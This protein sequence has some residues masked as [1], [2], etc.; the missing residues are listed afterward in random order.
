MRGEKMDRTIL[1]L[2]S[3]AAETAAAAHQGQTR[4]GNGMPYITH[5]FTV[6]LL[7]QEA[8]CSPAVITAGLLHDTIEDTS[9]TYQDLQRNFGAAVADIVQQC[10]EHDKEKSWEE[11]KQYTIAHVQT[12][13][14]EACMVICADKLHN[15]RSTV[16][17]K[18]KEGELVWKRFTRG[19]EQQ[20]W[21][22]R[23]M[24]EALGKRIPGFSLYGMLRREVEELF[25]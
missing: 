16:K 11:R 13:S 9:L 25:A 22:Y 2:F 23:S 20:E 10:S 1:D 12:I 7:L 17:G 14:P 24:V 15:I 8:G 19:R 6:A 21:Y 3:L 5:P 4:K 18:E